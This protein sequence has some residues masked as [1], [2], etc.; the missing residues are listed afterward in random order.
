MSYEFSDELIGNIKAFVSAVKEHPDILQVPHLGFFRE[1]LE[2]LG[3]KIPTPKTKPQGSGDMPSSP[4]R[5]S[6]PKEPEPM[7]ASDEEPE[8][9]FPEIEDDGIVEADTPDPNQEM[10]NENHAANDEDMDKSNDFKREAVGFYSEGKFAE[11]VEKYTEAIKL[12]SGSALLF[13]KR[14]QAFI[15]LGKPNACIRDCNRAL[16]INPDSAVAYKFRGRA[17]RLLGHWHDAASDLRQACKIDFD[18][19]ADEW[20]KEVTPNARK[21]EEWQ[22]RKA[23]HNEEKDLKRR[24]RLQQERMR[25]HQEAKAHPPPP[26]GDDDDDEGAGFG[27]PPGA[28]GIPGLDKLL[29]DPEI[30]Q[31][32]SD[33]EVAEAFNDITKNPMNIMKHQGNPKVAKLLK[34]MQSKMGGGGGMGGGMPGFGGMPGGFGGMPGGFGG[35]AEPKPDPPKPSGFADDLD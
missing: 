12:N 25:A 20:L 9:P 8:E 32:F 19:Q 10:G 28:G 4:R 5:P 11:S 16:Q 31:L 27:M 26:S 18:E 29:S 33:P 30:L 21:V 34:L 35:A 3:A 1:Y 13:A 6:A 2:S 22:I 24:K 7:E 15:Q 17:H 23:R 14:G